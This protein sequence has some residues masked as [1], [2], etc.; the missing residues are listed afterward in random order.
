M[1]VAYGY[2]TQSASPEYITERYGTTVLAPEEKPG[3]PQ[4]RAP[5]SQENE[6]ARIVSILI[7][8]HVGWY[9]TTYHS[10]DKD[11]RRTYANAPNPIKN[12]PAGDCRP[13]CGMLKQQSATTGYVRSRLRST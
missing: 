4:P 11:E 2:D 7:S 10:S 6:H 9:G 1:Y 13:E 5:N 8:I 3:R 12:L